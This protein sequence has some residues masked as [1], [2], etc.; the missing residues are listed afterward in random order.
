ME[1]ILPKQESNTW[2]PKDNKMAFLM[3]SIQHELVWRRMESWA[4]IQAKRLNL[5]G[6]AHRKLEKVLKDIIN[7]LKPEHKHK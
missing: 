7:K 5:E 3:K 2:Q 1:D 6:G 4:A